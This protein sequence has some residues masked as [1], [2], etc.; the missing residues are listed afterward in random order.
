MGHGLPTLYFNL[1]DLTLICHDN[2]TQYEIYL[3]KKLS[4]I[5]YPPS[6]KKGLLEVVG[7]SVVFPGYSGFLYQ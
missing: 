1:I 2:G 6:K 3:R 7:R 5:Y 4:N